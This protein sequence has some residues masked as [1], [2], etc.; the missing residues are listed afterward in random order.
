M[1]FLLS[2]FLALSAAAASA[3][4]VDLPSKE[5]FIVNNLAQVVP[6]FGMFEGTMYAG[7]LPVKNGNRAGDMMFWLFAPENPARKDSIQMW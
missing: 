4:S 2:L 6:E 7:R 1:A 5:D 3:R